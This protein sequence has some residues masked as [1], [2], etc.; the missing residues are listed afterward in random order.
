ML[1]VLLI[2][3]GEMLSSLMLGV[4]E[5]EHR[6]VGVLRWEKSRDNKIL[7]FFKNLFWPDRISILT[8]LYKIHEIDV[9]RANSEEFKK[10]AIKL[11]PDVIIVGSWGEIFTK[12]TIMIPSL[13]FVNC[14]PSLLPNHR[15]SNPY[16]S[17]IVEGET[18][19]GITFHIVDEGIDTGP[20]LLQKEVSISDND[21]AGTL[22]TKCSYAAQ[23]AV[24]ELLTEFDTTVIIPVKQDESKASYY[25]RLT[26]KDARIDWK[27][28]PTEIYNR[29]RGLNPWMEC[30]TIYK[31]DFLMIKSSKIV[32]LET[33]E[34]HPAKVL[35]KTRNS[36]LVSTIDPNKA[37]LFEKVSVY[38]YLSKLW[39]GFYIKN[40]KIGEYLK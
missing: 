21:N 2:G 11:N 14:H 27:K 4:L 28:S 40:I 5:S 1:K 23:K 12:D 29:I 24:K 8:K 39:S 15:G 9:K 3:Y 32:D 17:A 35:S 26:E 19:T 18:K 13:A 25:Q 10:Q 20:I 38:G 7:Y 22:R 6:L 33:P 37:I 36:L 31:K 16:S 34:P 30:Y